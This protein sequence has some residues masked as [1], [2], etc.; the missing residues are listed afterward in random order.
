[1]TRIILA[2]LNSRRGVS[3]VFALFFFLLCSVVGG[4]VLTAASVNAGK[5]AGERQSRQ[6]YLAVASAA[7]LVEKDMREL[8]FTGAYKHIE[9]TVT[10]IT[11]PADGDPSSSVSSTESYETGTVD[12]TGEGGLLLAAAG[13]DLSDIY[14]ASLNNE[15]GHSV[16]PHEQTASLSFYAQDASLSFPKVTGKITAAQDYS[17]TVTL[18]A[19]EQ[20]LELRYT[21]TVSR[22][23]VTSEAESTEAG[24]TA[25]ERV[26]TIYTTTVTWDGPFVEEW[27][28]AA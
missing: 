19:G 18:E 24:N 26:T 12:F 27:G 20:A 1:M 11:N 2:K 21:P 7:A 5:T 22:P 13:F 6:E 8:S 25:T 10:V 4:V 3:M 16:V 28:A 9:Q 23:V 17:I 15:L 14:F